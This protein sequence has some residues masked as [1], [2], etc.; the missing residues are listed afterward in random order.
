MF[1]DNIKGNTF[2]LDTGIAD[3]PFYRINDREII[4]LDSGMADGGRKRVE[5]F[6]K[7]SGFKV[8]GIICTHAHI[9]H[10]GNNTYLKEKYK[11]DI[12]MPSYEAFTCSS[13]VGLKVYYDSLTLSEVEEHFGHMVCKTDIMISHN[14]NSVSMCGIEFKILHTPGHSPAHICIVTPDNVG[15]LGDALISYEV[16]ESAK[17]PYAYI[18]KQD[19]ESKMKLYDLTCSKYILA[20]KGVCDNITKLIDDNI[21]FYKNRAM[22]IF[23]DINGVMKLEDIFHTIVKDFK[24][25]INSIYKYNVIERMLKSYLEYLDEMG[26][27]KQ[28]VYDNILKYSRI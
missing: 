20:H 2:Y 4:M 3:V 23:E 19:L 18:L 17:M 5:E 22:K 21:D 11:C 7:K 24:I 13:V 15:Y 26:M 9:D 10:I 25:P 16:M 12:A 8:S 28:G 1:V 14:Q 27:V 6:L